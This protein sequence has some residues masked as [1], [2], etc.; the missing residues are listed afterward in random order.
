MLPH[1]YLSRWT[2]SIH[3]HFSAPG[4]SPSLDPVTGTRRLRDDN[5]AEGFLRRAETERDRF[6]S[7]DEIGRLADALSSAEDQR[8][9][10]I[11]R[12]CMLTGARLGE[13]RQAR[14]EEFNLELGLWTKQAART[15]QRKVHRVP[16]SEDVAAIV[17][18]RRMLVPAGTPW[19]FPGAVEGQPVQD[20]RRFW[21]SIQAVTEL[22][23]V[24]MHDLRHTFASLLVSGGASLP[25]IGRLLGHTQSK[26]TQRY[27]HLAELPLRAGVEEVPELIQSAIR[28]M[29]RSELTG[30]GTGSSRCGA[31]FACARRRRRAA[32]MA[33]VK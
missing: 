3:P 30:S 13:V 19:L 26:T 8:A 9:A 2:R 7:V 29:T 31:R 6:L 23:D 25:M 24:R 16:I 33:S 20:L 1:R 17:R 5:P 15:K 4:S 10:S 22:P 21:R 32:R 12:L 11:V 27:A 28:S 18:Q 14:F